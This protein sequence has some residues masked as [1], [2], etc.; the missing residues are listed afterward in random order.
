M[1]SSRSAA[2]SLSL[3]RVVLDASAL[4]ALLRLEPGNEKV[5]EAIPGAVIS[6][7]NLSEVV[8]KL[9]EKGVPEPAVRSALGKVELVVQPFSEDLAY[10]TGI[11]RLATRALGLS[12]GDR[13]CLALGQQ[14]A[15]PVLTT[16]RNWRQLDLGVE[17]RVIR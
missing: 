11:L 13:A 7:V 5:A 2:G 6:T 17:V 10:R 15:A 4:L 1:S 14:L 3:S 8:S 12:L 16:D 9:L